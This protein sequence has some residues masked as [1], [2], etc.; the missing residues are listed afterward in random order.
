[1]WKRLFAHP[2]FDDEIKTNRAYILNVIV[3]ALI[4][5]P[6]PYLL[7]ALI[8]APEIAERAVLQVCFDEAISVFLLFLLKK[9]RVRAASMVLVAAFWLLFTV[10]AATG[11]GIHGE[12]YL[13]GYS[14]VISVAGILFGGRG[15]IA[16]TIL[17]LT[18]GGMM[19]YAEVNGWLA[20]G[21]VLHPYATW[22][23][24]VM[25]FPIAATLQYISARSVRAALRRANASEERYRLISRLMSD[26]TFASEVDERGNL[27]LVWVAGAFEALTGYTL[28][29]YI[30]AGGWRARLHP[31]DIKQD[32]R[33]IAA[34]QKNQDVTTDVRTFVKSGGTRWVRVYAH[35]V[36]DHEKNRLSRIVGAVQDIT[37]QKQAES[38]REALIA[39]LGKKNAELEQFTYT[40]SHDLKSPLVTVMGFIGYLKRDAAEGNTERMEADVQ[41]ITQATAK[42]QSLLDDLLELSRIGRITNPPV[43][44]PFEE[45]V[46]EALDATHGRLEANSV[47][48]D[49]QKDM[50]IVYGD[51]KRLV[52]VVQ[53]LVDNASKFMG[54]QQ[55]PRIEIGAHSGED[56]VTIFFVRDNGIGIH[57]QFQERIFGLFNKLD[58]KAD[59]TGIGLAIVKR[60]IEFH[61]GRIW[62]ESEEGKGATFYFTLANISK[63]RN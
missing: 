48:V 30:A 35:P 19:A 57:A 23:V 21:P 28:E 38:E 52:E 53:N 33:D 42:M 14:L 45:I 29:E 13:L 44:I 24:S 37:A 39:E 22:I 31:D 9:G 17:S 27:N 54:D 58:P 6:F 25:I 51:K 40:V 10:S 4:F 1:M 15:A 5:A 20:F 59:G 3:W 49:V 8:R 11:S 2:V 43:E 32:E 46:E 16:L 7:Y 56:N 18:V 41:R 61:G 55:E 60:I 34:L 12:S 47:K 36:W 63:E 50:P 62:V 26:Y